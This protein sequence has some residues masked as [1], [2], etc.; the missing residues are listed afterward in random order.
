MKRAGALGISWTKEQQEELSQRLRSL[1]GKWILTHNDAS[2]IRRLYRD[3]SV[4][5][6]IVPKVAPNSKETEGL[7][8]YYDH[9]II[10]NS[11]VSS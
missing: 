1:K 9:L 10:T 3:Y 4:E 7:R 2:E 5:R 6:V 8:D 11:I